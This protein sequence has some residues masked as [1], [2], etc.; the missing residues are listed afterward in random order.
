MEA[1][2]TVQAR[3]RTNPKDKGGSIA[4]QM[5]EFGIPSDTPMG[6]RIAARAAEMP[7]TMVRSYLKAMTGKS[8]AAG[9]HAFCAMCVTW[10]RVEVAACSDPACPLYRYRPYQNGAS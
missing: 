9:V 4:E 8:K 1:E 3:G 2:T 10:Q 5:V 7:S 6:E